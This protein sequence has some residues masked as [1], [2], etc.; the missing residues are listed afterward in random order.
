LL[1]VLHLLSIPLAIVYSHLLEWV[2]HKYVLHGLGKNK[3]SPWA[4]HWHVHHRRSRHNDN[5]DEDYHKGFFDKTVRSEIL[6]LGFLSIMHIP[7]I[8]LSPLFYFALVVSGIRYY[9]IHKRSHLDLE[10]AKKYVPWH[11][12][13]H[14]GKNQDVN[15]GVTTDWIDKVTGTR[16]CYLDRK[17]SDPWIQ[18]RK[19]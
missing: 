10:W 15:W 7:T 16:M 5:Y 19:E 13:H 17:A 12:D 4:S 11:Y 9:Q 1:A 14:M 2:L 8:M 18:I 3:K 6:G